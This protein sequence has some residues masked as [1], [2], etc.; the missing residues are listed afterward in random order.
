MTYEY[1]KK[2]ND[3]SKCYFPDLGKIIGVDNKTNSC[4]LD[5]CGNQ[6]KIS[7]EELVNEIVRDG[8]GA[9][10]NPSALKAWKGWQ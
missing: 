9:I 5:F 6:T 10:S 7:I 1:F 8:M 2:M 4:I 3:E